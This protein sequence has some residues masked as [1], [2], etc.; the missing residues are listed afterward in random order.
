MIGRSQLLQQVISSTEGSSSQPQPMPQEL[1][2]LHQYQ[3]KQHGLLN[4]LLNK[5]ATVCAE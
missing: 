4:A 2:P 5:D 1:E 3:Y